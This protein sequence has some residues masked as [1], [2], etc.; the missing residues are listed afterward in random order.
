MQLCKTTPQSKPFYDTID[1]KVYK[2]LTQNMRLNKEGT[3]YICTHAQ[4]ETLE[5][6]IP[7][8]IRMYN[9]CTTMF[10]ECT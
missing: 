6:Y 4:Q 10:D 5:I 8:R 2:A 1:N 3:I 7:C 9:I